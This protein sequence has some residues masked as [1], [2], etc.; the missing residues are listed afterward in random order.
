MLFQNRTYCVTWFCIL[1]LP[2]VQSTLAPH[3]K[4]K[5]N[6]LKR[7]GLNWTVFFYVNIIDTILILYMLKL[8]L[9]HYTPWRHLRGRRYSSYS[10]ST[11][12][13]DVDERSAS[14]P[15]RAL[16]PGKAPPVPIVQ[17]AGWAPEPVWTQRLEEKSSCLCQRSNLDRPV[18][19]SVVRHYTDWPTTARFVHIPD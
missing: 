10:F 4:K 11:S 7:T 13:Q 3:Q 16:T 6:K 9:S 14:R 15:G 18:V 17:E 2:C 8:K 12:A 1:P 5:L 19:Q